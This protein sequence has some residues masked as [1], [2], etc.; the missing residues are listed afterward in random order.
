VAEVVADLDPGPGGIPVLLRHYL[1]LGGQVLAFNVDRDFSDVL[2][3][4]VVVDLTR[5]ERKA[6]ERYLGRDGAADFLR[7]HAP[8]PASDFDACA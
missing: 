8:P 5:T 2:D 1:G 3:G 7:H 6:L 4:L